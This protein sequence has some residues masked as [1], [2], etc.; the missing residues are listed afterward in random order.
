MTQT[1]AAAVFAGAATLVIGWK[2]KLLLDIIR[3]ESAVRKRPPT[4]GRR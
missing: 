3:L 2:L 4:L 1:L